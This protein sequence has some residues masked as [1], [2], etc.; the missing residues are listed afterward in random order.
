MEAYPFKNTRREELSSRS[1]WVVTMGLHAL[2]STKGIEFVEGVNGDHC[3]RLDPTIAYPRNAQQDKG[4]SIFLKQ[5]DIDDPDLFVLPNNSTTLINILNE[6][7]GTTESFFVAPN[8]SRTL[9]LFE[10]LFRQTA[11]SLASL[12]LNKGLLPINLDYRRLLVEKDEQAI[13]ILPPTEL[14]H[15]TNTNREKVWKQMTSSL[16]ESVMTGAE[17]NSQIELARAISEIIKNHFDKTRDIR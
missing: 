5:A 15:T 9:Q 12:S 17:T 6:A 4:G 11:D 2:D 14:I 7:A 8:E 3:V 13:R 1:F 10:S 16:L